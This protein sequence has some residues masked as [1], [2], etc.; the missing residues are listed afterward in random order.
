MSQVKKTGN[1]K[2]NIQEEKMPENVK[3]SDFEA[4][5]L[6]SD[7]PV[8]VDFYADW[9]GPCKMLIPTIDELAKDYEGKI[10]IYKVNVDE[11]G[12]LATKYQVSS[13]PTLI[14]FKDG[15]VTDKTMGALPKGELE[16][17][18]KEHLID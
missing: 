5:V 14:L 12:E 10:K 1:T 4:K 6:K 16:N 7:T 13:I 17:K 2:D 15:Q 11:E 9:C 3:T 8:L 18:I